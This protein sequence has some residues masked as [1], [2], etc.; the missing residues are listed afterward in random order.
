MH[1]KKKRKSGKVWE[2]PKTKLRTRPGNP[3]T[4]NL[5]E[6]IGTPVF[7]LFI[8][9]TEMGIRLGY[10]KAL[11]RNIEPNP[12]SA[13]CTVFSAICFVI[14]MLQFWYFVFDG[15][16]HM[17]YYHEKKSGRNAK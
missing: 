16:E 9:F 17:E 1:K 5:C 15:K 2:T 14:G 7:N 12:Y 8:L 4:L 13:A 3:D 6:V 11:S 10:T